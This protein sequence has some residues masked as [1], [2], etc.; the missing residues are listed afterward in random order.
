MPRIRRMGS[1]VLN[2]I[3]EYDLVLES[4]RRQQVHG[5]CC[6]S[7]RGH[8]ADASP[9]HVVVPQDRGEKNEEDS[10]SSHAALDLVTCVIA[11]LQELNLSKVSSAFGGIGPMARSPYA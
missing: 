11:Y 10:Q 6:A 1:N 5:V 9:E 2:S 8:R 4:E 7:F 3:L